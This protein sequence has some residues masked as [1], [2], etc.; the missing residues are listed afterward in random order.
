MTQDAFMRKAA[1]IAPKDGTPSLLRFDHGEGAFTAVDQQLFSAAEIAS[2]ASLAV[3]KMEVWQ[4]SVLK[5]RVWTYAS[6]APAGGFTDAPEE[7]M[8]CRPYCI[9]LSNLYP[10]RCVGARGGFPPP[11]LPLGVIPLA[12]QERRVSQST[13]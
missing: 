13:S 9:F 11:S 10:M 3:T 1:A 4:V 5:L 2:V 12:S 8:A 6:I 7:G